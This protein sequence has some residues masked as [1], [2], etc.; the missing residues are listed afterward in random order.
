M[1]TRAEVYE[2][3]GWE[4]CYHRTGA[5][6]HYNVKLNGNGR[7]RG[8]TDTIDRL[9]P[10]AD[11]DT[12]YQIA[13]SLE[14]GDREWWWEELRYEL[15]NEYVLGYDPGPVWSCG[16]Q[17]GYV[18]LQRE[19]DADSM[20]TIGRYLQGERDYW[21]STEAGIDLAERAIEHYNE[22]ALADLASPRPQRIE[23]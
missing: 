18:H 12:L 19:P 22:Q 21:N 16:R 13:D 4:P 15:A 8:Y 3:A 5:D 7:F 6:W 23:A 20:M 14:Y 9:A 10:T 17:G 2:H 1:R 11:R